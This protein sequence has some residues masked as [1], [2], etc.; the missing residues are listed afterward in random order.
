[1]K[2]MAFYVAFVVIVVVAEAIPVHSVFPSP[3]THNTYVPF[4]CDIT[5]KLEGFF[6]VRP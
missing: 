4:S 1:M 2:L 6:Y 3:P 5:D